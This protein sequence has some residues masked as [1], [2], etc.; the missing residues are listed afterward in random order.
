MLT[1]LLKYLQRFSA[2]LDILSICFICSM[3]SSSVPFVSFLKNTNK[4][5]NY[6][7]A[8]W[9]AV[10]KHAHSLTLNWNRVISP[11][12]SCYKLFCLFF[13]LD[14]CCWY[15]QENLQTV[16]WLGFR[17]RW[18]RPCWIAQ[19][20]GRIKCRVAAAWGFIMNSLNGFVK[21][22]NEALLPAREK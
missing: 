12:C 5:Y 10:S 22:V 20:T 9:A 11:I 1:P 2:T 14:S 7:E 15:C 16:A 8:K 3:F 17:Y 19:S 13:V 4:K 18:G 6:K 21:G